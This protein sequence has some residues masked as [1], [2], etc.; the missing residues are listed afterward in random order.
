[1]I[2]GKAPPVPN[3]SSQLSK[4]S[5][6]SLVSFSDA[7]ACFRG[8]KRSLGDDKNGWDHYAFILRPKYYFR[9]I[10]SMVCPVELV[11]W[12]QDLVFVVYAKLDYSEARRNNDI[13]ISPLET[14]GIITH[15]AY[16]ESDHRNPL[17]PVEYETRFRKRIW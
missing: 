12:Q 17:M 11:P 6:D 9:Q 4:L 15:W 13:V 7:H 10:T 1:M 5:I 16:V 14:V 3:I 8:L 2:V